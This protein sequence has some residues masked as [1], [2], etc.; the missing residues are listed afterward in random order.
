[1][2]TKMKELQWYTKDQIPLIGK[3]IVL[4][5]ETKCIV[6]TWFSGDEFHHD[7]ERWTYVPLTGKDALLEE[8]NDLHAQIKVN[9]QNYA[10]LIPYLSRD[11]L[12]ETIRLLEKIKTEFG[13]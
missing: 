4:Y 2:I 7:V 1:M 11:L 13:K 10:D 9:I 12:H 8:I 5:F 3:K 6:G